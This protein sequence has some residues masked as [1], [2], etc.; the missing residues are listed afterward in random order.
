MKID[1]WYPRDL[2]ICGTCTHFNE[3]GKQKSAPLPRGC[4]GRCRWWPPQPINGYVVVFSGDPGCGQ[5]KL[6]E[7]KI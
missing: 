3:K 7:E 1:N 5:H 4:V 2:F 6:D